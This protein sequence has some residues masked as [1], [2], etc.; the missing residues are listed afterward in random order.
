MGKI[1]C[2]GASCEVTVGILACGQLDETYVQPRLVETLKKSVGSI[3]AS[4]V[5]VLIEGNRHTAVRVVA[6]LSQLGRSQT[7]TD[8]TG[9]I[10]ESR[11]PQHGEIEQSLDQDH[12]AELA[13]RFP[14]KQAAFGTGQ[15]AM[16]E[17]MANAAAIQVDDVILLAA[18]ENHSA[19]KSI[20]ALWSNQARFEQTF[21]GIA[22]GLQVRR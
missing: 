14:G 7:S 12:V 2:G 19:A 15:E 22:A 17:G 5:F 16:R 8:G 20:G 1:L 9:G 11:L 21:Q 13:D 18:R 10:A 3:L 4:P 6:E